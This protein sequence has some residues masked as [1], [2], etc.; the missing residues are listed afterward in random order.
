MKC[1]YCHKDDSKVT[2]SRGAAE[3]NVIR[4]RR[5][6]L[7]CQKRFSTLETIDLTIQVKK[8][9]GTYEDFQLEKLTKGMDTACRHT[10]VSHEQV[11]SLANK[12][13]AQLLEKQVHSIQ[14]QELGRIVM[15]YLKAV[16]IVAFI[17]F[18]C[19]YKRFKDIE[20]LIHVIE[21]VQ[22]KDDKI[23]EDSYAAEK[24]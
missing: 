2:D 24:K 6:C 14:T 8:R 17:R 7:H 21:S 20:E 4:R 13:M 16:D 1:P 18:A 3:T 5:E 11:R 12:I 23:K 19:V 22:S 9:D 15:D 10:R